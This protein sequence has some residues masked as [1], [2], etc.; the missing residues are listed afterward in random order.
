MLLRWR[1]SEDDDHPTPP[2]GGQDVI[3][4]QDCSR[5]VDL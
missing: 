3:D 1:F 5:V 2:G 4:L